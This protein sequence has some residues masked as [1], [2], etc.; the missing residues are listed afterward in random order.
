MKKFLL[1]LLLSAASTVAFATDNGRWLC[2]DCDFHAQATDQAVQGELYAF[3]FQVVNVKVK[4]WKAGDLVTICNGE[5]CQV[6]VFRSQGWYPVGP[7]FK[8]SGKG[9]KNANVVETTS[10]LDPRYGAWYYT[11]N[12]NTFEIVTQYITIDRTVPVAVA[13]GTSVGGLSDFGGG[14]E[15]GSALSSDAA[16]GGSYSWGGGGS[17]RCEYCV[18]DSAPPKSDK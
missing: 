3:I 5:Y 9:Y 7:K 13:D 2:G 14:F 11:Y 18:L 1:A 16:A 12:W 17:P 4:Q 10:G 15:W 8:D 6:L